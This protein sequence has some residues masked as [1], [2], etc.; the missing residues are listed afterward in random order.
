[1]YHTSEEDSDKHKNYKEPQRIGSFVCQRAQ[2]FLMKLHVSFAL[3]F[4]HD[5]RGCVYLYMC[6][7]TCMRMYLL[8]YEHA[9][10]NQWLILGVY[11]CCFP[12]YFLLKD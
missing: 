9:C 7:H 8:G 4:E 11:V 2:G 12:P 5:L 3:G 10:G 6:V 1:V